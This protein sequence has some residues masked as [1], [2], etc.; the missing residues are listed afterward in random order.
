MNLKIETK[1]FEILKTQSNPIYDFIKENTDSRYKNK[2]L[3]KENKTL[4][5]ES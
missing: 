1:E 3:C 4:K 5:T 2:N